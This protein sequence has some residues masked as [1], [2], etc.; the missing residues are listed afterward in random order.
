MVRS[1]AKSH[2]VVALFGLASHGFFIVLVGLFTL[3]SSINVI[4]LFDFIYVNLNNSI[5][6]ITTNEF[7]T[8]LI[9]LG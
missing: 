3:A 7:A 9:Y 8:Q 4:D 1:V 6:P 2:G 5:K